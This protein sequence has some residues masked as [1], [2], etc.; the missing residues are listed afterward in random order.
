MPAS[1]P[2]YLADTNVYVMAIND[3]TVR[4]R[5]EAF[6]QRHGP[7]LVSAIVAAEVLIGIPDVARHEAAVQALGAGSSI[8]AP[9]ADDWRRAAA[10]VAR[11]GCGAVTKSRSFWN[12]ALLA[13]QCARLGMT[14]LTHNTAD[15]RRLGRHLGVR[16]VAPFPTR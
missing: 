12:D 1:S 10:A 7:L 2:S 16:T 5:F 15:F 11:L 8:I 14:L 4:Q 13:A 3:P 9:S 6:V